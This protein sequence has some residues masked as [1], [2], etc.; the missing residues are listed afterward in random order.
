MAF[1][2]GALNFN[3]IGFFNAAVGDR[4]LQNN[5]TGNENTAVGT[6][7]MVSN[8]SGSYN[9]AIGSRADVINNGGFV[10]NATAIGYAA[11]VGSSNRI[12]LGNA[13]VVGVGW[14]GPQHN[15]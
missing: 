2:Q 5:T 3:E 6:Q 14:T 4:A 13:N 7:A 9:T 8:I 10:V 11:V 12:R 15:I 1:G